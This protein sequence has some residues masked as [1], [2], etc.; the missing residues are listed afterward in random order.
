MNTKRATIDEIQNLGEVKDSQPTELDMFSGTEP[1]AIEAADFYDGADCP[2]C[3]RYI[4]GCGCTEEAAPKLDRTKFYKLTRK[5]NLV[6]FF[7]ARDKASGYPDFDHHEWAEQAH[8]LGVTD[9]EEK[10]WS[11]LRAKDAKGEF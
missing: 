1:Y 7:E 4:V 8:D 9:D 11:E 2:S 6:K 3:G 5:L 10:E